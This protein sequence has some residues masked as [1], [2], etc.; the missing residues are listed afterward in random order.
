MTEEAYIVAA[1][2]TPVAPR[3][4]KLSQVAVHDLSAQ[5]ITAVLDDVS[6]DKDGVDCV[7]LGNALYGGGN[8]ARLASL[9]AGL[10]ES[11]TAHTV[12]TQ[13]CSGMD[14]I[15]LGKSLIRAGECDVVLAGGLESYSRAPR[16]FIRGET[17]GDDSEY[18]RPP[19]TP[20]PERDPDMIEAAAALAQSVGL[21]RLRQEQYAVQ[22]HHKARLGVERMSSEI[23]PIE[24]FF[25][26]QFTR[27]LT[28]ETCAR[29]PVVLGENDFALT[30]ATIAVEADAAAVCLLVSPR[31]LEKYR[32]SIEFSIRIAHSKSLGSDPESPALAPIDVSKAVLSDLGIPPDDIDVAEV[33]EAFACQAMVCIEEIG[34]KPDRVNLSGGGLAR[35]HPIGASGVINVVRLFHEMRYDDQTKYGLATI[36]GAGGLGSAVV[37]AK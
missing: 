9:Q 29:L 16:R 5:V 2:R 3:G 35:G 20:W 21:S 14:A 22:S 4:G 1:K 10:A 37:L 34:L 7:I 27:N 12:D 15:C 36:A 25:V 31:A 24:G 17:E 19:F 26:D 30:S 8:P 33:M 23:V 32:D 18:S 13:C 28:A 6:I 11:V